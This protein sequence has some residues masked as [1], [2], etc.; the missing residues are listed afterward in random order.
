M[1]GL[2]EIPPGKVSPHM[3]R[4]TMATLTRDCPGSEIA[5]GMQLK[6]A[7]ARALASRWTQDYMD[8]DPS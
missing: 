2:A 4:R 3:F 8:H 1:T 5:V 6:H 7:A